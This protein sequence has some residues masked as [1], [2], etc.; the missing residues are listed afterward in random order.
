MAFGRYTVV[1]LLGKGSMGM[2]YL[3]E[4]PELRRQVAPKILPFAAEA[5]S[6]FGIIPL[7]RTLDNP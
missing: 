4:D 6:I 3:A 5:E 2:V 7:L 1:K